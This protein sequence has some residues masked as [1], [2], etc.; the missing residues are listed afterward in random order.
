MK[1]L[2]IFS[3]FPKIIFNSYVGYRAYACWV[4]PKKYKIIY[5]G[6]DTSKFKP[7]LNLRKKVENLILMK[8]LGCMLEV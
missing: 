6:V 3:N 8:E 1:V 5:N 4:S 7:D 2:G